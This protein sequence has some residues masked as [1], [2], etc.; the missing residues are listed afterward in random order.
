MHTV[1]T[2]EIKTVMG[3]WIQ[4][5]LRKTKGCSFVTAKQTVVKGLFNNA[6]FFICHICILQRFTTR[7]RA[8][9]NLY[10][11]NMRKEKSQEN[12][13]FLLDFFTENDQENN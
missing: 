11:Y 13:S 9:V 3:I 1:L 7:A 8:V 5:A 12:N 10:K 2:G 6:P 4:G